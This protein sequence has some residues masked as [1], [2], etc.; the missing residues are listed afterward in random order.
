MVP[1]KTPQVEYDDV[2]KKHADLEHSE[3]KHIYDDGIDRHLEVHRPESLRGMSDAEL[4][5]MDK[6]VTR[7]MD[8]CLMPILISLYVLNFLDRNSESF[9]FCW[10]R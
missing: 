8:M 5:A 6:R 1:E 3:V 9:V 7:K 4:Q 2:E 10:A